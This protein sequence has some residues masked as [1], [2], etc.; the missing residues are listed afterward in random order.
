MKI[1]KSANYKK[2]EKM[3]IIKSANYKKIAFPQKDWNQEA[4]DLAHNFLRG[5]DSAILSEK[6]ADW[7]YKLLTYAGAQPKREY[8]TVFDNGML[9][10]T[11]HKSGGGRAF[12]SKEFSYIEFKR[13]DEPE[14]TEKLSPDQIELFRNVNAV[15]DY[16]QQEKEFMENVYRPMMKKELPKEETDRRYDEFE[17][18]YPLFEQMQEIVFIIKKTHLGKYYGIEDAS[19]ILN[20]YFGLEYP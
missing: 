13:V 17:N 10:I 9:T 11:P 7:L 19:F 18:K 16:L 15:K 14:I 1:L 6:Q 4:I 8:S 3:K 2:G 5:R 20:K 12:L